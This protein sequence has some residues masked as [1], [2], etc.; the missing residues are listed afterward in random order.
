[1]ALTDLGFRG[2]RASQ[3]STSG[4]FVGYPS[5]EGKEKSEI[6]T[7]T[8]SK[9][10]L[11]FRSFILAATLFLLVGIPVTLFLL[12]GRPADEPSDGI[13]GISEWK[14]VHGKTV[15]NGFACDKATLDIKD[16]K[17]VILAEDAL[18]TH[19]G[20]ADQIAIYMEKHLGY[21]GHPAESMS[22]RWVRDYMGCAFQKED[23]ILTLATFGEWDSHIEGAALMRLLLKIP[24]GIEIRTRPGLSG[25]H[26]KAQGANQEVKQRGYW[27]PPWP[28]GLWQRISSVP[29]PNLT[30][31]R[32]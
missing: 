23:G 15:E 16:I 21:G 20:P 11:P 3:Q 9:A 6:A 18:V 26:S 17:A 32:M 28:G 13:V 10:R 30:A 5:V 2:Q 27:R 7:L 24:E 8:M 12:V 14:T 4:L 31:R 1:V 22:I 25:E 19:D 29:D